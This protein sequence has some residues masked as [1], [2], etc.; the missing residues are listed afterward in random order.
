MPSVYYIVVDDDGAFDTGSGVAISRDVILTNHHVVR[1]AIADE[2]NG[3]YVSTDIGD[4]YV[5]LEAVI[6]EHDEDNDIALLKVDGAN[7][8]PAVFADELPPKF[9]RV[10][11]YGFPLGAAKTLTEGRYQQ[12]HRNRILVTAPIAPGSSGGPIATCVSGKPEVIGI[13]SIMLAAPNRVAYSF[14]GGAISLDTIR[15]EYLEE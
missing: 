2:E 7:F 6:I 11:A 14:M 9:S 3:V 12:E 10:Y 8:K 4:D 15:T 1:A 5:E 13:S